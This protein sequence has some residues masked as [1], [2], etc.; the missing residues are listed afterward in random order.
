MAYESWVDGIWRI[1]PLAEMGEIETRLIV[2]GM[3]VQV[4]NP[5]NTQISFFEVLPGSAQVLWSNIWSI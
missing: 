4:Y 3:I 1:T 2:G 5:N